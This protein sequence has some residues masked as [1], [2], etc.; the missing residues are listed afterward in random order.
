MNYE[1][2]K[3]D[4]AAVIRTNGN[5]EITGEVLQYILLMMVSNLGKA[6]QFAGTATPETE[7]QS[8]D[9]NMAWLVGAGTYTNFGTQFTVDENEL[10]VV[11]YNGN[12]SVRKVTIGRRT[13]SS[14]TQDGTNPVESQAIFAEFKKL[15]D[16]GYLFAGLA[17]R[18]SAPPQT[19][20]EKIFYLAAQG[21]VYSNYGNV[22]VQQGL[23]VL[24]YNGTWHVTNI[25]ETTDTVEE[26]S[27]ALV[28]SGGVYD[29]AAQKVDKEEGKGLSEANFTNTEK[30][31][32]GNLPTASELADM[33]DLKQNVLLWDNAP[34]EGSTKAIYSGAVYEAI[35]NFI[36]N[37]VDDLLNY[38]TKAQT[39]TKTQVDALIAAV[40]QFNIVV[41]P[42][43][44]TASADTM[45]TLY[46]VP[47]EAPGVQNVKDE[48]ITLSV[49]EG[50]TT[51]Y[52]WECIGRTEIDLSNYPT[53]D[54]MNAAIAAVLNDYY[55]KVQVDAAI[56]AAEGRLAT[57]EIVCDK[58]VIL[59]DTAVT[60]NITA[61]S[62]ISGALTIS[63]DG[64]TKATGTGK[65]LT[66]SEIVL[67]ATAGEIAYDLTVVI[68][69]VER[70]A[71]VTINVADA[72]YYGA[73][74][75][76]TDIT[77]KASARKTPAGRYNITAAAGDNIFILCPQGM[78]VNG[79]RMSNV[80]IPM[81]TPTGVIVDAKSY[82]C[83]QSSNVYDA[84]N[85][86]I[87]VY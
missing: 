86:V 11:M 3:T 79:V 39:Y 8:Q 30:S 26:N 5:E 67:E 32:L 66:W 29:V 78:A 69:G 44:P 47:S 54:Q 1:Q 36:T 15:R 25:F 14:I 7:V 75:Q 13:D 40:H 19:I 76:A 53:F 73:G 80:D 56:A 33:L 17:T 81:Q 51:R 57:I 37:A 71:R 68:G 63:R 84:G 45:G 41:V 58:E 9:E 65:V 87:E 12:Y 74:T 50:S 46:L 64:V 55:T 22:N 6:F 4:I 62:D 31:K 10:G 59:T 83:Y 70:T 82:L 72:V 52:Y 20:T 48:Y 43:L 16:A 24:T 38:Y 42:E 61:R 49:T 77:T 35:K 60:L 34:V 23:N 2:L 27:D 18:N 21:G 28:T 85:Y